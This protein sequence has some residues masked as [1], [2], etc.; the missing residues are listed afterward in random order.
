[1][2][3][4]VDLLAISTMVSVQPSLHQ[5]FLQ[6]RKCFGQF[7][8]VSDTFPQIFHSGK[9]ELFTLSKSFYLK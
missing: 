1:M 7:L 8:L 2:G 5:E 6:S 3:V 4:A 9:T